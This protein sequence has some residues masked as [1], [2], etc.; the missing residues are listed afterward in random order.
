MEKNV[1]V[2]VLPAPEALIPRSGRKPASRRM[3]Q[4]APETSGA[5][6]E[7]VAFATSSG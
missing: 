7:T 5:S 4:Q 1:P 6:F 3:L 2:R